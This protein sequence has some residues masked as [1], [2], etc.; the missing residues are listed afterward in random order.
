MFI[1]L[2]PQSSLISIELLK[3]FES[4]LVFTVGSIISLL[5]FYF[6]KIVTSMNL[7]YLELY[8]LLLYP[9]STLYSLC[10]VE[11]FELSVFLLDCISFFSIL[12]ILILVESDCFKIGVAVCGLL[13]LIALF[14][15]LSIVLEY[16]DS[17][18]VFLLFGGC[19]LFDST[20]LF[21]V[22]FNVEIEYN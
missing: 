15:I 18:L 2:A 22:I 8:V 10:K 12:D 21:L 16:A 4:N 5:L 3:T 1:V 19:G 14:L 6:L 13:L 20:F 9:S 7:L 11:M 17:G